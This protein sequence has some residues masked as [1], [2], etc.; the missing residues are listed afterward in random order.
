MLRFVGSNLGFNIMSG[1]ANISEWGMGYGASRM[2]GITLHTA[3]NP[4][5]A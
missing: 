3:A 4:C 1:G 5:A 2:H